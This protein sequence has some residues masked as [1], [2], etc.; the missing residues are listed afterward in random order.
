M[1]QPPVNAGKKS[2]TPTTTA[3]PMPG[4]PQASKGDPVWGVDTQNKATCSWPLQV[5]ASGAPQGVYECRGCVCVCQHKGK[6]R[7]GVR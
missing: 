2:T 4:L 3:T 1:S 6:G 5:K 7:K